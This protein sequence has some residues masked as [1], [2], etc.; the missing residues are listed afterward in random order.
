MVTYVINIAR[1]FKPAHISKV[2]TFQD[3]GLK[4]NNPINLALWESRH[5]WPS[6]SKPDLVISLGTGTEKTSASPN[7]PSFRHVIWDG[8][9]PR[10]YRSFISSL[11]GQSAWQEL[12]NRLS[13]RSREDY[14][15][16]NVSLFDQSATDDIESM[17]GLRELVHQQPNSTGDCLKVVTSLLVS[18]FFFEFVKVP[19]FRNG[20][21][22]CEGVIR[23]RLESKVIGKAMENIQRSSWLFVT[24]TEILGHYEPGYDICKECHRYQN[25]VHFIVRRLTDLLSIYMEDIKQQRRKISGFPQTAQWFLDQ[26]CFH[27]DFGTMSHKNLSHRACNSCEF[28]PGRISKRKSS[29]KTNGI[30]NSKKRKRETYCLERS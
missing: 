24:D 19:I 18:N 17:A 1:L 30:T 4:H 28:A 3:G 22:H 5:I 9:I 13:E 10:L 8:F 21:Y 27:A 29:K 26:Q 7:A 6:T 12:Q 14:F 16:L 20:F 11:D 25:H 23:S 15:R 2:G